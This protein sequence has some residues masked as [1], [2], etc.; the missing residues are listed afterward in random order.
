MLW[1]GELYC[2]SSY[3]AS[4]F[5]KCAVVFHTTAGLC[6]T[7]L[8]ELINQGIELVSCVAIPLVAPLLSVTGISWSSVSRALISLA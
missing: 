3:I 8:G 6:N 1:R 4:C 7:R 5:L 2:S